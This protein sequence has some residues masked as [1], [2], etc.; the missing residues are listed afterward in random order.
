M[1]VLLVVDDDPAILLV[2]R[3][4]FAESGFTV[5][6]VS[7]GREAVDALAACRPDVIVLDIR[8]P[9]T[10]GLELYGKI[11]AADGK[12]PVIFITAGGSSDTV[13]E[14][15]KLGAFDY[16]T[17]PLDLAAVRGLLDRAFSIRRLMNVPVEM[18]D[19]GE[20]ADD[21]AD[22]LVGRGPAMQEVY[23]S[24]GRVAPQDVTVLIRGESGTGKELI[25]RAIYQHSKRSGAPFLAINCAAIPEALLESEL[26]GHEK[27]AF[28]GADRQRIGKFEQCSGGTLL[29]DEIGDMPPLLQTK[30]LRVLQEQRF[31]RVGGHA[32]VATDVRIIAATH[33]DLERSIGE[34][35]F[36]ADLYHRLNVFTI[37]LPALRDRP[38]DIPH[39]AAHYIGR[40]RREF[41]RP[42]DGIAPDALAALRRYPWPGNVRELQAALKQG[43]LN[44]AAP[45][46]VLD[47]LPA[48]VRCV[49]SAPDP[50]SIADASTGLDATRFIDERLAASSRSLY[51]EFQD[52][53]ER[54]LIS[55][56]LQHT[57]GNQVRA[58]EVLGIAR[59]SLRKKIRTLGITIDRVVALEEG[60]SWPDER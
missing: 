55:R 52:L 50:G 33:Q 48:G 59:N 11:R 43:I 34:G 20:P 27:G 58:A 37:R 2:F 30:M 7:T 49:V 47:D 8:L 45:V 19:R 24:I 35:R 28:T 21:G 36:R 40:Y 3:R 44:A 23:K 22:V 51:A 9:D 60:G 1:P 13:I 12:I 41:G 53:T 6:A 25:A 15:M 26:F 32:T 38:E 54:H 16:L 17:K 56:V 57:K 31:E 5:H 46:L 29:L 14:A 10:T 39:L 4:A 18:S 42:V